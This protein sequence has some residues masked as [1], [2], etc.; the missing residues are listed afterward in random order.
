LLKKTCQSMEAGQNRG[1]S[2]GKTGAKTGAKTEAKTEASIGAITEAS[3]RGM[4]SRK[5][6]ANFRRSFK[7][8]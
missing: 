1:K 2:R 4:H 7:R 3:I 6:R 8:N 5:A